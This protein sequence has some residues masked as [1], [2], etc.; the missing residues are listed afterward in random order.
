VFFLGCTRIVNCATAM[1]MSALMNCFRPGGSTA[2]ASTAQ[3][4]KR[5]G[6][7]LPQA[8]RRGEGDIVGH[9]PEK[10]ENRPLGPTIYFTY[11]FGLS[12][13]PLP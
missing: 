4:M 3:S 12:K 6:V 11:E 9:H 2:F 5:K 13:A 1:T 7:T 10:F 8:H